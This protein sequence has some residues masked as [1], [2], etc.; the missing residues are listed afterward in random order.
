ME[1]INCCQYS[2]VELLQ[3]VG[4]HSSFKFKLYALSQEDRNERVKM[5]CEEA[6][7]FYK[8]IEKNGVIYTSFSPE[9]KNN[10]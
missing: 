9:G 3:A 1:P 10:I 2:F 5:M 8:D 6:G 7:W 4:L